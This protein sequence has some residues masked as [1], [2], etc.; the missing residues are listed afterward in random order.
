MSKRKLSGKQADKLEGLIW[1]YIFALGDATWEQARGT[2]DK[3]Y[4]PVYSNE[5]GQANMKLFAYVDKLT[6]G[7]EDGV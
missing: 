6:K 4:Q 1:E 3:D 2:Y 5:A 7:R